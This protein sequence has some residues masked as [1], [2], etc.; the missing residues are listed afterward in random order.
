MEQEEKSCD[1]VETVGEFTYL[2]ARVSAGGGCEAAVT[3][4]TL[5]GWVKLRECGELLH[6]RRCPLML[7]EAVHKSYVKPAMLYE[8]EAWCLKESQVG[9]LQTREGSMVRTMC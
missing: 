7:K 8:G 3:A 6:G 1:K 9:I 4:K 2:G 5:C